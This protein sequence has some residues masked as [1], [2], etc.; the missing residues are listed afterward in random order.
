MAGYVSALGLAQVAQRRA[1]LEAFRRERDWQS[2]WLVRELR[3]G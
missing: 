3:L 2:A 1:P